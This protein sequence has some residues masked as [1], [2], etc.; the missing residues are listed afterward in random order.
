MK[1]LI[2]FVIFAASMFAAVPTSTQK[3]E[4]PIPQTETVR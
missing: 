4:M 3:A 2:A 1:R